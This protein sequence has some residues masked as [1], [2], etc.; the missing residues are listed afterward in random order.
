MIRFFRF[1]PSRLALVYIALSVLRLALFVMPLWNSW[2]TNMSTFRAYVQGE[3]TQ[4]PVD[5][6]RQGATGHAT[7]MKSP[8][9]TL[10]GDEI[11]VFADA[12]KQRLT[13]NLAAWPVEVPE[14]FGAMVLVLMMGGAIG[15]LLHRLLL[16]EARANES[17]GR[18]EA[19][20]TEAQRLSLTGSFGWNVSSG[21]I[22]WS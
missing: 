15:W 22:Y 13:V 7:A 2:R 16:S 17:L 21:E 4:R 19:Y 10:P 5:F 14:T 1:S 8:V 12:S 9:R 20:L 3:D 11:L 18:S 6:Y